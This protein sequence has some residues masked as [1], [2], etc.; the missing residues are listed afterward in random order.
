MKWVIEFRSEG[1]AKKVASHLYVAERVDRY[2]VYPSDWEY[3]KEALE[4]ACRLEGIN[5]SDWSS[6]YIKDF[7]E[8]RNV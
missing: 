5:D 8:L 1:D 4:C 7:P 3:D 2:L 6:G